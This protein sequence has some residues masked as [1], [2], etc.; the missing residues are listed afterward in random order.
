MRLSNIRA[1]QYNHYY[2]VATAGQQAFS[3]IDNNGN[4]LAYSPGS[5]QVFA[6]GVSLLDGEDFTATNGTSVNLSYQAGLN[7]NIVITVSS[8]S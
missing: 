5:I 6:N 7:D 4:T 1:V 3:G 2:Y 8:M